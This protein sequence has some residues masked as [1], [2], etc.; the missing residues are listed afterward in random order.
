MVLSI[1]EKEMHAYVLT[2]NTDAL[3]KQTRKIKCLDIIWNFSKNE[4]N[5]KMKAKNYSHKNSQIDQ[6]TVFCNGILSFIMCQGTAD[7]KM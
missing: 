2:K 3:L 7:G 4:N 5:I 6:N 1:P